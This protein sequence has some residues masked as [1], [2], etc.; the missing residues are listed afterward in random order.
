MNVSYININKW[1]NF[2]YLYYYIYTILFSSL[3]VFYE[4]QSYSSIIMRIKFRLNCYIEVLQ[5][6]YIT[7]IIWIVFITII[8]PIY[9]LYNILMKKRLR[10]MST[11]QLKNFRSFQFLI[12]KI[13]F[14]ISSNIFLIRFVELICY[15]RL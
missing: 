4:L 5:I 11:L 6:N 8:Y 15:K 3:S 13:F 14:S 7:K 10:H 9:L 2:F 1:H 12:R